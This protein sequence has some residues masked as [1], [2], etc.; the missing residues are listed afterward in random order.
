MSDALYRLLHVA[1][2][3]AHR[4]SWIAVRVFVVYAL[5]VLGMAYAAGDVTRAFGALR[6]PVFW[7]IAFYLFD[8]LLTFGVQRV[9]AARWR[10]GLSG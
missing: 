8:R 4:L 5:L 1:Y 2:R 9:A 6:F 3:P 7:G 10:R